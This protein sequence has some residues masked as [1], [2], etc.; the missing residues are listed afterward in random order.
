MHGQGKPLL[1]RH[2]ELLGRPAS[3][4]SIPCVRVPDRK[5]HAQD[6]RANQASSQVSRQSAILVSFGDDPA[7]DDAT[8]SPYAVAEVAKPQS[9]FELERYNRT[10]ARAFA[11]TLIPAMLVVGMVSIAA[12]RINSAP[13]S[14][15]IPLIRSESSL[16]SLEELAASLPGF[17]W[18]EDETDS[19]TIDPPAPPEQELLGALKDAPAKA[20]L[21]APPPTDLLKVEPGPGGA[22]GEAVMVLGETTPNLSAAARPKPT[23]LVKR[24]TFVPAILETPI[25]PDTPSGVRALVP[26]DVK[27]L[28]SSATVPRSSRLVGQYYSKESA[29]RQRVFIIWK[30][31]TLPDGRVLTL[32]SDSIAKDKFFS[33]FGSASMIS[34]LE[35]EG[36]SDSLGRVRTGEALRVVTAR[37][38]D[39]AGDATGSE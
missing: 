30:Q 4:A 13:F 26:V 36:K 20:E 21:V 6:G 8:E 38:V 28:G 3:L 24:G 31:L 11:R 33:S 29:G 12:Y 9:S 17:P 39:L 18:F 34:V 14:L 25:E 1:A 23:R 22:D 16:P 7:S 35:P 2:R 15:K 5:G 19:L 37:D 10:R 27:G 32:P